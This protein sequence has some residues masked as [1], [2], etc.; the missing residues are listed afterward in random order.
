MSRTYQTDII[1]PHQLAF[2]AER[3]PEPPR[4]STGRPHYADHE[5]LPGIP[6]AL[7]AGCCWRDLDRPGRPSG[8]TH[9]RLSA[10]EGL[11]QEIG[12]LLQGMVSRGNGGRESEEAVRG[13]EVPRHVHGHPGPVQPG[14][15]GLA[16]VTQGVPLG[17]DD[18][19]R[20]KPGQIRCSQ[21]RGI[22]FLPILEPGEV[23]VPEPHHRGTGQAIPLGILVVGGGIEVVVRRRE[24]EQL[25]PEGRATAI[26]DH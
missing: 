26:A 11:S 20:R 14:G 13:I 5:R 19:R 21:R 4:A 7:R 1:T 15:I 9:W 18:E 2:I 23:P 25:C 6:R 3:L 12:C 8:I 22:R 16:V 17:G 10:N 24:Q